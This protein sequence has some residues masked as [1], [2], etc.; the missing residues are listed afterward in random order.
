[1]KFIDELKEVSARIDNIIK[2]NDYPSKILPEHLKNAVL[3]YPSNAGKRLRPA[4]VIWSCG[5]LDGDIEK[6]YYAATAAEIYHN[7]TLVHDD[8]I[9]CDDLRRGKPATHAMLSKYAEGKYHPIEK[10]AAYKFGTDFGILAGDL[11]QS[12]AISLLIK[13]IEKGLPPNVILSLCKD[14]TD[15]LSRDLISGEAMD[16][17]LSY[18]KIENVTSEEVEEM[19][20]LKTAALLS[21]CVVTGAKIALETNSNKDTRILKLADYASAIGIAFQ[22]KDDWLGIFSDTQELGKTVGSDI[23]SSKPTSLIL[24]ALSSLEEEKKEKLR[25]Y[26]GKPTITF[27][28]LCT[29]RDIIRESGAEEAILKKITDLHDYAEKCLL[30]FPDNKYKQIL[31]ELNQYLINRTK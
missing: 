11:Q 28:D 10:E 21:F 26:L 20:Y 15:G 17:E 19:I 16:V 1:M 29:I 18:K 12:W 23:T 6:A 30:E 27:G 14:M 31:L 25:S 7:W 24:T 9:D 22:L 4:L 5:L 13:S 8:I 2:T 3:Q